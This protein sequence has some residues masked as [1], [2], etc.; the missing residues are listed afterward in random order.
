MLKMQIRQALE[1]LGSD[2]YVGKPL[3]RQLKGLYSYRVS[4]YRIVYRIRRQEILVEVIDIAARSLVYARVAEWL[5]K[6]RR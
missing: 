6:V 2:P 5:T 4:R 1:E 3:Q